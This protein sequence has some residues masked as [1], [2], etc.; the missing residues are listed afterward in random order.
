MDEWVERNQVLWRGFKPAHNGEQIF[1]DGHA[2]NNST[3]LYTVP[4]GKILYIT[5][6]H[7]SFSGN[8]AGV[9]G[10]FHIRDGG[11]N[12]KGYLSYNRVFDDGQIAHS[13]SLF[14][15][16]VVPQTYDVVLFSNHANAWADGSFVGFLE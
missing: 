14:H 1:G 13:C 5:Y 3:I 15:P 16:I 7:F 11:D 10:H 4:I 9:V 6:I 2:N 8:V 12:I